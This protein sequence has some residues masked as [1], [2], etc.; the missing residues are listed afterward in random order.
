MIDK[1]LDAKNT[2][3]Y[4]IKAIGQIDLKNHIE[5]KTLYRSQAIKAACYACMAGYTDGRHDCGC[6]S[7]AL[8]PWMP[9]KGVAPEPENDA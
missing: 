3:K 9:Y 5:G 7:C 8:Y 1:F 4:G 6:P 2:V